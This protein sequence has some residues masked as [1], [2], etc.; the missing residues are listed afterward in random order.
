MNTRNV[1]HGSHQ[2]SLEL[3]NAVA[4]Y[5]TC[6]LGP[7]GAEVAMCDAHHMLLEDQR[8]LDGLLFAR[9]LAAQLQR[10]EWDT[11]SGPSRRL[12]L[13]LED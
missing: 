11:T 2:E 7:M 1:W 10:E 9:R 6:E 4:R 8:A 5:C 12:A 13:A 3:V